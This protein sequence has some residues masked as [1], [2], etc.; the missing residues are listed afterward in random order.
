MNRKRDKKQHI[1]AHLSV[2]VLLLLL[3]L[4]ACTAEPLADGGNPA[5]SEEQ[6]VEI[7]LLPPGAFDNYSAT[8]AMTPAQ[9]GA[10]AKAVVLQFETNKLVKWVDAT[11]TTG[12]DG[13]PKLTA[14]IKSS[15][16]ATQRYD[17][18]V[19]ANAS[20]TAAS[21]A[22][23]EGKS[24]EQI[25][26][27]LVAESYTDKWASAP[28]PMWGQLSRITITPQSNLFTLPLLRSLARIDIGVGAYD[29]ASDSWLGLATALNTFTLQEVHLFN[30][31]NKFALIPTPS[32][33]N[34]DGSLATGPSVPADATLIATAIPPALPAAFNYSAGIVGGKQL[35]ASIYLPEA[36]NVGNPN[37]EQRTILVIGGSYKG[38]ST[39]Y[40]RINMMDATK[41]PVNVLRNHRYRFTVT[42]MTSAG[43]PTLAEARNNPPI[44]AELTPVDE[45][46]AGDIVFDDNNYLSVSN[47]EV[48]IYADNA[49]A[50]TVEL[51]MV[52]TNYP[53]TTLPAISGTLPG[54]AAPTAVSGA[55]F[56]VTATIPAATAYGDYTYTITIGR[57]KKEIAV[58][59]QPGSDVHFDKFPFR[60]I[61]SGAIVSNSGA[62]GWITLSDEKAYKPAKQYQRIDINLNTSNEMYVHI[63]E[64]VTLPGAPRSATAQFVR[65]N[66]SGTLR[67]IFEQLAPTG[68]ISGYFGGDAWAPDGNSYPK[69]LMVEAIEE[70]SIARIY[71]DTGGNTTAITGIQWGFNNITTGVTET[72]F[73]RAGTITLAGRT[74]AGVSPYAARYCYDKN[75]DSNGNGTLDANEVLWYLPAQNQLTSMWVAKSGMSVTFA[76]SYYAS[77]VETSNGSSSWCMNLGTALSN[78]YSKTSTFKVRCVRDI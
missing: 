26:A 6:T 10:I 13:K 31:Q 36:N 21:F 5:S 60:A 66:G 71:D 32:N 35:A 62:P 57:L 40:Y 68:L 27:A 72:A 55:W 9:E 12:S 24:K 18:V 20:V 43:Y 29:A 2:S 47:A 70:Y 22:A 25:G 14:T 48:Q 49:Q 52:K 23:Y 77:V 42:A 54:K 61:G 4:A 44:N 46:N 19:L 37:E 7:T 73:G 69:Q 53:S 41:T 76:A 16:K 58:R 74:D 51:A 1:V 15:L 11:A 3:A 33:L 45:G 30:V 78:R 34:F 63:D 28:I 39:T 75:R 38:G 17:L 8:R 65:M 56:P 59:L 67:A 50:R 64:N